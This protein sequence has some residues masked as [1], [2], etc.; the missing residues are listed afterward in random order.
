M[1]LLEPTILK[2]FI[3]SLMLYIQILV[4]LC[5]KENFIPKDFNTLDT[6]RTSGKEKLVKHI[7][8]FLYVKLFV[9]CL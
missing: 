6:D 1:G 2:Y 4:L 7:P 3:I 5:A 8:K 9:V